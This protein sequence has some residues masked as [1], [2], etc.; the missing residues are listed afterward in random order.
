MKSIKC[1]ANLELYLS[2]EPFA[3]CLEIVNVKF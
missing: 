3:L 2:L 1:V